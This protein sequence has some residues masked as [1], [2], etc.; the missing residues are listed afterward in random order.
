[1]GVFE[2][3]GF[4][5]GTLGVANAMADAVENGSISVVGGGDSASAL[6]QFGL[7]HSMS[8][9]STGGGASLQILSGN[10]L[11]ALEVLEQ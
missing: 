6:N 11:P 4:E 1:M 8:H 10:T 5:K 3:P 7:N 2:V 9:V